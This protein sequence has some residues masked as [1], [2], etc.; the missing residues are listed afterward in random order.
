[1][2]IA[3]FSPTGGTRKAAEI[4][5]RAIDPQAVEIDLSKTQ[6]EGLPLELGRDEVLLAAV[7]VFG[8]RVPAIA[9]ERLKG[10]TGHDTPAIPV[11]VYGNRDYDDA[12]LELKSAL[13]S[14][15]FRPI[16]GIACIAEHSIM[17][18]YATGRPDAADE[19][20]L[21]QFASQIVDKLKLVKG[22]IPAP[23]EVKGNPDYKPYNGVPLKPHATRACN[24]CGTCAALCPV[25][26]IP[27]DNPQKT[28]TEKCISCMRCIAVCPHQARKVSKLKVALS[29]RMLKKACEVRKEPELFI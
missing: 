18:V 14:N 21:K 22:G 25:G 9:L 16:A 8:G 17:H 1:M 2:Y 12:Q 13:E 20:V 15:G 7:P 11:V 5:G 3:L 24:R 23:I 19:Q 10:I 28:D 4:I 27:L 6:A 26:A 29:T